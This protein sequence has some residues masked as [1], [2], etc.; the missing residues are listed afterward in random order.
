MAG[1][2][3][4]SSIKLS[5]DK[6]KNYCREL[7]RRLGTMDGRNGNGRLLSA[8]MAVIAVR[9]PP[10][11]VCPS[12]MGFPELATLDRTIEA[13][14]DI[15]TPTEWSYIRHYLVRLQ[16]W[17]RKS[18]NVVRFAARY[19]AVLEGCSCEWLR[20]PEDAG[21][22]QKDE[23]TNLL[24]A[25]KR[26]VPKDQQERAIQVY[27]S[28]TS[29][30]NFD[31]DAAFT[32]SFDGKSL[33]LAVHAEVFLMEHFYWNELRFLENDRL[34]MRY[35]PG[36]FVVRPSHGTAWV[37]WNL[38]LLADLENDVIRKHNLDVMNKV[39]EHLRR[40]VL[41]ELEV[42]FPRRQRP[43]DSTSGFASFSL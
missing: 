39:V 28:V 1:E 26:M 4:E 6:I 30:R 22:P 16:S 8:V 3:A 17:H 15:R 35:H 9:D 38:P 34:N 37:T 40:D 24:G 2:I 32:E 7:S 42:R 13:A 20:L 11:E 25:L 19:P 18:A 31:F 12:A 27:E 23:K 21:L 14:T 41:N 29:L 36:N 10:L 43:P 33:S 5:K